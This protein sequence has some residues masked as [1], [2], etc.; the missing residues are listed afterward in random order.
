MN[1][2]ISHRGHTAGAKRRRV[3]HDAM[4]PAKL[5]FAALAAFSFLVSIL[6]FSQATAEIR[7][8]AGLV[9]STLYI[10]IIM[11]LD[12]RKKWGQALAIS[13]IAVQPAVLAVLTQPRWEI[14]L[15]VGLAALPLAFTLLKGKMSRLFS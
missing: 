11:G 1:N 4:R 13:V 15:L 5:V 7:G 2:A 12:E 3:S 14:G 6:M 10:A 8:F 9:W